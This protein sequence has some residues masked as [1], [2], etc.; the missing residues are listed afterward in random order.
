MFLFYLIIFLILVFFVV[1]IFQRYKIRFLITRKD[2]EI[3]VAGRDFFKYLIIFLILLFFVV[4]LISG[5]KY[6]PPG[7]VM[8]KFNIID[9]RYSI[10]QE[11]LNILPPFLYKV[12]YYNL[13]LQ[14]YCIK[15]SKSSKGRDNLWVYVKGGFPV[16]INLT[17][18][19]KINGER[20][21]DFH[22]KIGE[23]YVENLVIPSVRSV[24]QNV[25]S[26]YSL[27]DLYQVD[28]EKISRVIEKKLRDILNDKGIVV[29]KVILGKLVFPQEY[30]D[31]LKEKTI[32]RNRLEK[33]KIEAER[34][35]I[36][37]EAKARAISIVSKELRKYP[38]YIKYMYVDK[39]SDKIKV[40]VADQKSIVNL[41]GEK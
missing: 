8:L 20:I 1:F 21:I 13:K 41:G 40:I 2:G 25:I 3:V 16:G 34:M 14:S 32:A 35:R 10:S 9:K 11:G 29:E 6:V 4:V 39:L 23:D 27:Y 18:W 37:A 17:C 12:Y 31:L 38:E 36:E 33:E 19:Y 30:L 26:C 5:I 7:Y 24:V 28:K 22:K 15:T